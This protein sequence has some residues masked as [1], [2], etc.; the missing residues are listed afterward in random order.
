MMEGMLLI[1]G[2]VL[3]GMTVVTGIVLWMD[4]QERHKI[5]RVLVKIDE[6]RHRRRSKF[7]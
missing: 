3:L 6:E 5:Y 1:L 2:S 7:Q 4:R